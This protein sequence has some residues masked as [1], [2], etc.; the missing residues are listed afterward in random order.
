MNKL[1]LR[2][3]ILTLLSVSICN[4]NA[5]EVGQLPVIK[6]TAVQETKTKE[7]PKF[8]C[9]FPD[10]YECYPFDPPPSLLQYTRPSTI[11]DSEY[12]NCEKVVGNPIEVSNGNKHQEVVYFKSKGEMPLE[13]ILYY[14]T[15]AKNDT[16]PNREDRISVGWTDNFSYSIRVNQNGQ[17]IRKLPDGSDYYI[18]ERYAVKKIDGDW[19]VTLPDGGQEIYGSNGVLFSKKNAHGIGWTLIFENISYIKAT[20]TNGKSINFYRKPNGRFLDKI[21]KVTD[22]NG[23]TYDINYG[24]PYLLDT[25]F[26]DG[27][28]YTYHYGE[29]GSKPYLLTG[30]SIN[31]KRFSSYVYNKNIAIQSGRSD[32]SQANKFEYGKDYTIVTNPLGSVTKYIYTNAQ[33]NK[34]LR[35]ERSGVDSCPN[36]SAETTYDQLGMIAIKK[37][38]NNIETHYQ[39]DRFGRVIQETTGI[40]NGNYNNAVI[41]KNTWR[42]LP[43]YIAKIE[44]FNASNNSLIKT[45]SYDY[46]EGHNRIKSIKTCALDSCSTVGYGYSF[47]ANKIPQTIAINNNG[48][49]TVNIYDSAGNLLEIRN[50]L[51]QIITYSNYDGLGNVGK[52]V[53]SNGLITNFLYDS[54]SRIIKE[55]QILDQDQTRTQ[56]FEY[57]P[58]GATQIDRNGVR[59]SIYYNNNGTVSQIT[60]GRGREV[61]NSQEYQY[62]NLG[63]LLSVRYKESGS[64]RYS[65]ANQ[66][67]QL[68]WTT[69]DLGNNGQNQRYEYDANGNVIKQTDSLGN[70]TSYSYDSQGNISRESRSDGSSVTYSYDAFGQLANIKDAKGNIT[71]YTYDGFGQLLSTNSPDT[72]VTQYQYDNDGNLIRLTRANNVITTYSYDALNRRIKAQSGN[73]V[74]TWVYDNCINGI[75]QLCATADGVTS[76]GYG[77]TKDG[78]LAVEIKKIAGVTYS[79]Y[80]SYDN[81]GNLIGESR[82][83]DNNKVIYEYDQ[84]NR[85]SAVKFKTG[86]AI[87][88][89]VNNVTYEPYGAIKSWTYGNGLSR[90]TSYDQD[91]RLTNI[92]SQGVQNLSH[93]YNANNWMTQINNG[94][95]GNKT[96][97][98]LYDALGQLNLASSA[99]YTER[100]Q[101]DNNY[102]RTSR[103]GHN[104]AVTNYVL[105]QGNRLNSTTGAEA[106]SFSY[107][108]VGNLTQKTG[109]GG[110]ANY[111]Y[112]GFN[113]L[114]NVNTGATVSYDYDVFNL[115]SRKSGSGGT[116]NYIYSP[117]GRL[118]AESLLSS[119][120]NGSLSKIYIWLGGQPIG[121]VTNNQFYYI[122]NDHLGRPEII[123]DS[124]QAIVWKAQLSSYDS[125]V[126]HSSIGDFNL[127][128][129]GQYFDVESALWYNWNRYYDA[130][131]GRYTQSDPIGL[132]G[133]LNSYAYV[134]NNPI[135]FIDENGEVGMLGAAYGA[136]AGGIGGYVTGGWKGAIIGAG[137]G[138]LVGAVNP[139]ASHY[140]GAAA[141][142]VAANI[143]GQVVGNKLSK[144][145]ITDPCN[146]NYFAVAGAAIGGAV[147]GPANQ[148]VARY[149]PY[150]RVNMI[151][152]PLGTP[153]VNRTP[154][155]IVGAVVEG[156]IVGAGETGGNYIQKQYEGHKK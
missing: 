92:N 14:D 120:Q 102:N 111:T 47:H 43:S 63:Q 121:F 107:D 141:G 113:R 95:D 27:T 56:T 91:Y 78:Q 49:V 119:S 114:K 140:V 33:K 152:K 69:A 31:G 19:Y 7:E 90:Q 146:Y 58:F 124:N 53:D 44:Y 131:I 151:G 116:I 98:Y 84:L 144:K 147:G 148:V 11:E 68:G 106:K 136:V 28:T 154:G 41:K 35:M 46:Y 39:R 71:T 3:L 45:V 153:G 77:Y 38:W 123:T 21:S 64:V 104:N 125:A 86:S 36:S 17:L 110:T 138:A 128:F 2:K 105:G 87:Q 72:G 88:T 103:T 48:K 65:K 118:L 133:G 126:V 139:W 143:A 115:R 94:L 37:D 130:S 79:T 61:L 62:S 76:T 101:Q 132:A 129:P 137:T 134:E 8:E 155:L 156:G 59:E 67:N 5:N 82:E 96:T 42:N 135:S 1:Q 108:S 57:G 89:I 34:L 51:G 112:D 52:I 97:S 150:M 9:F 80:W 22:P 40:K 20:H 60:H 29:N 122:H 93:R 117:E 75:G 6:V 4:T 85:V 70:I 81:L 83:N 66:H 25:R 99:Q 109:Y 30:I 50:P 10:D 127:G 32:G 149:A 24:R 100:W 13:F 54:R 55:E 142:S 26:P 145:D 12:N 16:D 23:N 18:D 73:H 74:Q 15:S